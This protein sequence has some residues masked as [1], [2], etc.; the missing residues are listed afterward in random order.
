MSSQKIND[1]LFSLGIGRQYLGYA[2]TAKAVE[3]V[4]RDENCLL[5]VKQGILM[6]IAR[7]RNCD[8]RTVER[9]MRT[10]VHRAWRFSAERLA[11][12]AVYPL[13]R[14]PTVTEF[15]DILAVSLM[16]PSVTQIR[17]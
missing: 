17:R 10:V 2:I 9:N 14:E 16:R 12:R 7:E 15:L 11:E 3:M 8:W 6:P 5:C 1:L 4:L 13:R